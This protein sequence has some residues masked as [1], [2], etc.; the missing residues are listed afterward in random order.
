M[1]LPPLPKV[2]MSLR[3]KEDL[4]INVEG[5]NHWRIDNDSRFLIINNTKD[6]VDHVNYYNL[7]SVLSFHR[8]ETENE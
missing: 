2:S 1:S 8:W 4:D 7:D 6:D 3:F 5:V